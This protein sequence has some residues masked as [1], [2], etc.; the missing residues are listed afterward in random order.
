MYNDMYCHDK[1][2]I[3]LNHQKFP[4]N[5][6]GKQGGTC[7]MGIF[8]KL[9]YELLPSNDKSVTAYDDEIASK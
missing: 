8:K 2:N 3:K 9:A 1:T 5:L 6:G 7:H 4:R